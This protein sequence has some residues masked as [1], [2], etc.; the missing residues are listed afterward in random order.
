[1]RVCIIQWQRLK[2]A[3]EIDK[4]K[5]GEKFENLAI[6][7]VFCCLTNERLVRK[8]RG[9]VTSDQNGPQGTNICK[10]VWICMKRIFFSV[11]SFPHCKIDTV[12]II[13]YF[14]GIH[15]CTA[16]NYIKSSL[17]QIMAWRRAGDKPLSETMKTYTHHHGPPGN[18]NRQPEVRPRYP[19]RW[20]LAR[21][22]WHSGC[23]LTNWSSCHWK[24]EQ[25]NE[26]YYSNAI[27]T[28]WQLNHRV[29]D[30]LI[31]ILC[32]SITMDTAKFRITGPLWGEST[33]HRWSHWQ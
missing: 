5:W 32:R 33:S 20:P 13:R 29:L 2:F 24:H 21:S 10:N 1:M 27:R 26:S 14:L 30:C 9:S 16:S 28:P 22:S 31:N 23:W 12:V 25:N 17:V 8:F 11:L 7:S 3:E 4:F 15:K 19:S 18:H 6:T